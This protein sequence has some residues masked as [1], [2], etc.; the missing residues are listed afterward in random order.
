[1]SLDVLESTIELFDLEDELGNDE[2]HF[3]SAHR[4]CAAKMPPGMIIESNCGKLYRIT[5]RIS[6]DTSYERCNGCF[7]ASGS[8]TCPVCR[9]FL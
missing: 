2:K 5:G 1:M 7:K 8:K 4:S 9:D 3:R 6:V